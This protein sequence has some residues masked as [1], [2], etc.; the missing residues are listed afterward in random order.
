MAKF[1]T[2]DHVSWNSEAGRVSGKII[3]V[4]QSDF[5]Y[6]GHKR[7]ASKDDPQYEIESDKSDHVAAHKEDALTRIK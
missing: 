6:K 7:R 4:H 2:G 1:S 5:D 3:K